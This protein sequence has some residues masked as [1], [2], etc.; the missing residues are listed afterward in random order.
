ML[1]TCF[2][3]KRELPIDDFYKHSQMADGRLG[4]CKDCAKKDVAARYA[5]VGGRPEYERS[6]CQKPERRAA[7]LRY[8]QKRRTKDPIKFAARSAVSNALRDGRIKRKPCELCGAT[9][10]IQAH[11]HDYSKPLDVEWLCFKCHRE[12]AHGQTT[13]SAA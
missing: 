9:E 6:R 11:H 3:C 10:R 8:N 12:H 4:K 2:K 13:R 5:L 1:K 7:M